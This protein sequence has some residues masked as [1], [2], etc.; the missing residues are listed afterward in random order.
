MKA[1]I[2]IGGQYLDWVRS[3]FPDQP[4]GELP[5]A[6]KEWCVHLLD[7]LVNLG[8][9]SHI[10]I[11]DCHPGERLA[12]L[13]K[14]N[15]YWSTSFTYL[16]AT[17]SSSPW[18]LLQK[19]PRIPCDPAEGML[20]F[21]GLSLPDLAAPA[22]LLQ[23]LRPVDPQTKTLPPGV[24]LWQNGKFF[25]CDC[26]MHH[27][28]TIQ[29]YFDLNFRLLGCPGVYTLPGYSGTPGYGFGRN[30]TTMPNCTTEPPLIVQDNAFLGRSL[31]LADGVV[32]GKNS[33]IDDY[34]ELRHTIVL[35]NTYVGKRLYLEDKIVS[36]NRVIDV[37]TGAYIDLSDEFLA[38]GSRRKLLDRF[39]LVGW[40]T[41][42]ALVALLTP[43]YL[44]TRPFRRRLDNVAFFRLLFRV[45]PGCW[46][47]LFWRA[48]LI[49]VG[50][51]DPAYAFRY[52]DRYLLPSTETMRAQGD[53]FFQQ[54]RTIS[55]M[56][57]IVA[58]SLLKR[59]VQLSEPPQDLETEE[60]PQNYSVALPFVKPHSPDETTIIYSDA[61]PPAD[62]PAAV[63]P[64]SE[65]R[66]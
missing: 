33:L 40:L 54:H 35:N 19:N 12:S 32:V 66:K 4:P 62:F 36:G 44:L 29:E 16:E 42:L 30:V 15:G 46:K 45:Y 1:C 23:N 31:V 59:M 21:W 24:Y 27:A 47:V 8:D 63:S 11:A 18:R 22:E 13:A 51:Q 14:R 65:P 49:R 2:Y 64:P 41:A 43:I 39:R 48:N 28:R 5:V 60:V 7:F 56:L 10:Y 9:V 37:H 57:G 52:M 58:R 38:K 17:R 55:L 6:G 50:D 25:A 3:Y 53:I 34:T 26:P 20:L 61:M